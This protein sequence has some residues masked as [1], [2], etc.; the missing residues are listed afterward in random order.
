MLLLPNLARH[1][2]VWSLSRKNRL[3][4]LLSPMKPTSPNR[5]NSTKPKGLMKSRHY[6]CPL[7]RAE[8]AVHGGVDL[9]VRHHAS[10]EHLQDCTIPSQHKKVSDLQARPVFRPDQL[11]RYLDTSWWLRVRCSCI[12]RFAIVSRPRDDDRPLRRNQDCVPSD[13]LQLT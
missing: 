3:T 2:H 9:G 4:L 13:I 8:L 12:W 1:R 5:N 6:L 10:K 7:R 11:A